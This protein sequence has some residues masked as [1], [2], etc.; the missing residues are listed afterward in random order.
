M[1]LLMIDIDDF[2]KINDAFG[3]SSGDRVLA[4]FG[5]I[6]KAGVRGVDIAARYGEDKFVAILPYSGRKSALQV[7]ERLHTMLGSRHVE[8]Q[9]RK[10]PGVGL[11]ASIGMAVFPENGLNAVTLEDVANKSLYHAKKQGKNKTCFPVS[12]IGADLVFETQ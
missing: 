7:A 5:E 2:K 10:H 11:A 4:T 9:G 8:F 6:L 1:A 12:T 3:H